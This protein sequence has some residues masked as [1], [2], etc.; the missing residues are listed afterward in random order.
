MVLEGDTILKQD[1][2]LG[3]GGKFFT[4]KKDEGGQIL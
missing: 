3:G 4:G 1:P 2:F